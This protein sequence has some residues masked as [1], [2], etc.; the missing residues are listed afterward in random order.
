M[1]DP[2]WEE[3]GLATG[4]AFSADGLG[5]GITGSGA[6]SADGLATSITS[7][8]AFSGLAGKPSTVHRNLPVNVHQLLEHI[9]ASP[10]QTVS[11]GVMPHFSQLREEWRAGH[12]GDI[13]NLAL[14]VLPKLMQ[15]SSQN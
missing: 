4:S 14:E 9:T 12:V 5:T 7:S 11:R 6:F 15:A 1:C 8:G 3:D 10:K 2:E 13:G